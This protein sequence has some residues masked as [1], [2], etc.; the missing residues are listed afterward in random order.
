MIDVE[1]FARYMLTN[2]WS[3]N[4]DWP[5]N[6][7][8]AARSRDAGKWMF[9]TW[10]AEFGF[11]MSPEGFDTDTFDHALTAGGPFPPMLRALLW[12]PQFQTLM[13]AELDRHLTGVLAPD[14]VL[15]RIAA[16][17]A[18]IRPDI[19]EETN[20][21]GGSLEQWTENLGRVEEFARQRGSI[22]RNFFVNSGRFGLPLAPEFRRGDVTA[23]GRTNVL[24]AIVGLRYLSGVDVGAFCVDAF[25]SNDSGAVDLTDALLVLNFIFAP[26]SPAPAAPF[27]GCGP[28]VGSDSQGCDGPTLCP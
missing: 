23:D 6:N 4:H 2:I 8:Y 20:R 21:V 15:A 3:Q 12:N 1:N 19:P 9:F 13:L 26:G 22:I 27:P 16:A 18:V 5:I 14:R 7:W 10:D 11:G 25:D 28:D 17:A 24:D